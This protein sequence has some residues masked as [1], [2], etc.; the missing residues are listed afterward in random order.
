MTVFHICVDSGR[1]NG[2]VSVLKTLSL[3]QIEYGLQVRV[4]STLRGDFER[5]E[6]IK[7]F[8]S[9]LVN[10]KPD[11]VVFHSLYYISYIRIASILKR[12]RIP[13]AIELHGALSKANFQKGKLKKWL[14]NQLC[15][16]K[17][18]KRAKS[19]I[20]LNKNEY[21]NSI[22][23]LINPTSEII[24]NGCYPV[25]GSRVKT[26]SGKEWIEILYVGRIARHHKGLDVLLEAIGILLNSSLKGKIKFSFYGDGHQDDMEWFLQMISKLSDMV[27]YKGVL[28]GEQKTITML[29][30][31]LFV[32]TSRYEG[33]PMGVLEA[34]SCGL[35]C[36][37]TAETNMGEE[38]VEANAGWLS[39][40]DVSEIAKTIEIAVNQYIVNAE[41][42]HLN[43]WLLSKQYS[44]DKVAKDSI[45]KYSRILS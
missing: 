32:L 4:F 38:V 8:R 16:N 12:L 9:I 27:E 5:I 43:A 2:I 6:S 11:L 1:P 26:E 21:N 39:L 45:E 14:V 33:M 29:N 28:H 30:A 20:Y 40:L 15:F 13:Y 10:N 37:L 24:P 34:L 35:P 44:W 41:Q 42:F 25:D 18:I 3:K 36:L 17:F 31:D 19:I 23:S 22:V 7:S